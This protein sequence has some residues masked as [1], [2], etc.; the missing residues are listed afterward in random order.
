MNNK[1]WAWLLALLAA[2]AMLTASCGDDDE[3]EAGDGASADGPLRVR[4][5][6]RCKEREARHGLHAVR[7][8]NQ[9]IYL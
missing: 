4:R 5:R 6:L 7:A 8:K 3:T 2:F 1:R 9:K